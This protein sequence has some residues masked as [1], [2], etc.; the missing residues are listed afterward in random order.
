M[1]QIIHLTKTEAINEL[2]HHTGADEIY[3]TDDPIPSSIRK[4]KLAFEDTE[5]VCIDA[6]GYCWAVLK[7]GEKTEKNK[8]MSIV[9]FEKFVKRKWL[10]EVFD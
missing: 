9:D 2:K 1:K 8:S 4:F 5:Y 10:I 7:N 6:Q 3:I